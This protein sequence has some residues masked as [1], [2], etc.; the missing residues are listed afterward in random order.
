MFRQLERW[1]CEKTEDVMSKRKNKIKA[2]TPVNTTRRKGER[3]GKFA[4]IGR[5]T[6]FG[7]TQVMHGIT[8]PRGIVLVPMT[9]VRKKK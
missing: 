2:G 9:K 7:I 8:A 6:P 3:V 5:A 1:T 4:R